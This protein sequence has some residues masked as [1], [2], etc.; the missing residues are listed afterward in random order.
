MII[1]PEFPP[2]IEDIKKVLKPSKN[3]VF[4][5]GNTLYCPNLKENELLNEYLLEH[6]EVHMGQQ[7]SDP[8]EWWSL[9]LTEPAFRLKQEVEAYR[10]QLKAFKRKNFDRNLQTRFALRLAADLASPMYG[11]I[12]DGRTAFKLITK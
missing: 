8:E 1:K 12:V 11:S 10:A 7:V 5:Y 3:A 4:T 6:E 2:N 9:Y